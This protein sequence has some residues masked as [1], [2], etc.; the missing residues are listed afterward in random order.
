MINKVFIP[1][2]GPESSGEIPTIVIVGGENVGKSSLFNRLLSESRSLVSPR[3][4]TTHDL[5]TGI[6]DEEGGSFKYVDTPA[7]DSQL[8]QDMIGEASLNLLVTDAGQGC[9]PNDRRWADRVRRSG[10]P[11]LLVVNKVDLSKGDATGAEFFQ[12]GLGDPVPV[13][14]TQG[15]GLE[16]LRQKIINRIEP[17][18]AGKPLPAPFLTLA[19]AGRSNVGKSTLINRLLGHPRA[20]VEET[21]GTTRDVV[22]GWKHRGGRWY[23]ILDTA[24]RERKPQDPLLQMVAAR[25]QWRLRECDVVALML[26][27]GG[28]IGRADRTFFARIHDMGKPVI[29]V[30]NKTDLV[31]GPYRNL[32]R[33]WRELFSLGGSPPIL[34][35]SARTG[36]GCE[37]ILPRA[38]RLFRLSSQRATTGRLHRFLREIKQG[39]DHPRPLIRHAVQVGVRPPEFLFFHSASRVPAEYRTFLKN[40]LRRDLN[41]ES[42]P[43][44][45]R[46]RRGKGKV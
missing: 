5:L 4:G 16:L 42:V 23:Q 29:L 21:P 11:V 45:V 7:S 8:L 20:A 15:K 14:I 1:V 34:L 18:R 10:R 38:S 40:R 27:V 41:L 26:D 35:I 13:S 39:P 43:I 9:T 32:L 2:K 33:E 6:R 17:A 19:L 31:K 12:L 24:G 37:R 28:I 36:K 44:R 3:P 30:G 46:L 25:T 22:E